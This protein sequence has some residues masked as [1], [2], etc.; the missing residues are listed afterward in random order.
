MGSV[1][2]S[3]WDST[4][5]PKFC[6]E[7]ASQSQ[8]SAWTFIPAKD[9]HQGQCSPKKGTAFVGVL[10]TS[11][12]GG[13]FDEAYCCRVASSGDLGNFVEG[14]TYTTNRMGGQCMIFQKITGSKPHPTASSSHVTPPKC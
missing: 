7:A 10:A 4:H 8:A 2:F 9:P 13:M 5:G 14:Y 6:C 1:E 11:F 12:G 3:G